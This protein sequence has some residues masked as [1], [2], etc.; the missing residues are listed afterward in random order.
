VVI[1][2]LDSAQHFIDAIAG[3]IPTH[4]QLRHFALTFGNGLL[5]TRIWS[6]IHNR[7]EGTL[8]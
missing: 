2:G 7:K 6:K 1:Q 8:F 3:T 5:L 4:A